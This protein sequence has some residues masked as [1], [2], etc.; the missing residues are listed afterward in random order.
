MRTRRAEDLFWGSLTPCTRRPPSSLAAPRSHD[1]KDMRDH[2]DGRIS[3]RAGRV[4]APSRPLCHGVLQPLEVNLCIAVESDRTPVVL[5]THDPPCGRDFAASISASSMSGSNSHSSRTGLSERGANGRRRTAHRPLDPVAVLH[6]PLHE[7]SPKQSITC[8]SFGFFLMRVTSTS[9]AS[10]NSR[11]IRCVRSR[12]A[13]S[14]SIFEPVSASY[15][16]V[17][18]RSTRA[19]PA[20]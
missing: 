14:A 8:T 12:A 9:R 11:T 5:P 15:S 17:T 13:C 4:L 20:T 1:T 19:S 10:I 2:L 3:R 6:L 16:P 18:S 7:L